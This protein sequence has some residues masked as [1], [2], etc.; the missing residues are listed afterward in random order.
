M[1]SHERVS[2]AGGAP[3]HVLGGASSGN[4]AAE[5]AQYDRLGILSR[6]Y[7][8]ASLLQTAWLL[9]DQNNGYDLARR[10]LCWPT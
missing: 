7:Y 6:D 9:L 1:A 2:G 10:N 4:V 8:S 5:L 3:N